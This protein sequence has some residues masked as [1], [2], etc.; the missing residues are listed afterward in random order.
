[1]DKFYLVLGLA[2]K[3][4][5]SLGILIGL[6][7]LSTWAVK[8]F[9][10]PGQMTV[11]ESQAMDM[12]AM[13]PP[14]GSVPVATEFVTRGSFSAKV[15]YTGSVAP[16]DEQTI[17]PRIEGWLS[18]LKVYNGDRVRAGQLLAVLDASGG[19][20]LAESNLAQ[21]QAEW[22]AALAEVQIARREVEAARAR[23]NAAQQAVTQ[24]E[25]D[26]ESSK[27]SLEYWKAEIKR[28]ANLLKEGAVSQQEY[29]SE[30]AQMIAAE[31]DVENKQARLAEMKAGVSAARAEFNS[32]QSS[33]QAARNT[34]DAAG[35][36]RTSAAI[37]NSYRYIKAP[38]SGVV[39]KRYISPGVLVTPGM[40]ILNI[41][42]IDKVRLQANVAEQDLGSI[43]IGSEVV[44]HTAQRA[45]R[46]VVTSISPA[47]D[48]VSHTALVEAIVDNPDH[49]LIPGQ[50]VSMEIA[51][52]SSVDA[53]TV[54]SS[55]ITTK[56]G[57]DAVWITRCTT[58]KG[59]TTYYCTMHP[60]VVSDRPS[61]CPKCNMKL[62]PEEAST[63]KTA[64]LVYV[65]VGRSGGNRTE[66]L[67]GLKEGDEV[68][69]K[70]HRYLREG[71]AITTT[72]W[73]RDGLL[74]LPSP[75]GGGEMMN[76]PGHGSHKPASSKP[77]SGHGGH[78]MS[79]SSHKGHDM[80][81]A[82]AEPKP[83]KKAT[84][85]KSTGKKYT[86]P[87]HPEFITSDPKAL[88]PKCNMTLEEMKAAPRGD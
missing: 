40:A 20:P 63:G 26:L 55:A 64:R 14:V 79:T 85:K 30:K 59:E 65:T 36:A 42:Q 28:E 71:D 58:P 46:G 38:F 84:V 76:M 62:E 15:R 39:T 67:T 43:R 3:H 16:Y 17:Y 61:L 24:A 33:I 9:K 52:S 80:G 23:I 50:F 82:K 73:G 10:R 72:E 11:I 32:K 77:A 35:A 53:I 48:P 12:T 45:I 6:L 18:G 22:N 4:T 68:I 54:P 51:V 7:I 81:P 69:Y 56:D 60:E 8:Y 21:M 88:C 1:M 31:A 49:T 70:G 87:M 29:E 47:A 78:Q 41:A 34:A 25:K 74:E 57:Q 44:A 2:R 19:V 37:V 5:W 83:V 13:K 27:A 66:I 86:C 75:A